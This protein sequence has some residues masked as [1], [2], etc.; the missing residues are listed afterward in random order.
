MGLHRRSSGAYL[1]VIAAGGN[2]S[3]SQREATPLGSGSR[4]QGWSRRVRPGSGPRV[5]CGLGASAP[6]TPSRRFRPPERRTVPGSSETGVQRPRGRKSACQPQGRRP[7]PTGRRKLRL[8]PP[9]GLRAPRGLRLRPRLPR[10]FSLFMVDRLRGRRGVTETFG[11]SLSGNSWPGPEQTPAGRHA[12]APTPV[13]VS[14]AGP[15][16]FRLPNHR[17]PQTRLPRREPT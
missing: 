9:S 4:P 12:S 16:A 7:P 5:G 14:N 11:N 3:A 8:S 10:G 15:S 6:A 2:L 17:P 1:A 13:P